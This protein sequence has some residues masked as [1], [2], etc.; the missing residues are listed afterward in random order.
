[1]NWS[2]E[3]VAIVPCL[4]EA[5]SIGAVVGGVRE[6]VPRVIVVDDGSTDGTGLIAEKAGAEVVRHDSPMGKGSALQAGLGRAAA[7]G[8]RWALTLDGDGQHDPLEIPKFFAAAG[9]GADLVL[10]NRMGNPAEMPGIRMFVNWW[11]SRRISALAG[12][13]LP[14][15]Q[16]GFRLVNLR[17]WSSFR[18]D[19][20]HFDFE[21]ELLL[22]FVRAGHGVEFVPIRTIYRGERSKIRPLGDS[23]RWFRWWWRARLAARAPEL[24]DAPLPGGLAERVS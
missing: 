16:C 13:H 10:G 11:M 18:F 5:G 8:A 9:A 4:N 3:C 22:E 6:W 23:L 24:V 19:C 1:M 20:R 7:E 15:S 12:Q 2:A 21:S 17:A 14:D